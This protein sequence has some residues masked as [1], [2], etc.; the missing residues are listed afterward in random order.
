MSKETNGTGLKTDNGFTLIELLVV[1]TILM[2]L[3]SLTVPIVGKAKESSRRAQ[4]LSNLRQLG[5]GLLLY[6][7]ENQGRFPP[8]AGWSHAMA[9]SLQV[10]SV[11]GIFQCP[12]AKTAYTSLSNRTY[13]YNRFL[14]RRHLSGIPRPSQRVAI[15]DGH[16]SGSYFYAQIDDGIAT[17]TP[18][19]GGKVAFLFIDQHARLI[20]KVESDMFHVDQ[21]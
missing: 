8:L 10:E 2:L 12:T 20:D 17:P 6:A 7:T 3:L 19:H 18:V 14:D 16:W 15:G 13:G 5:N 4:C 11:G 21:P 9:P 1:I